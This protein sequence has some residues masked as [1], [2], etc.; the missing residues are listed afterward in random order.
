MVHCIFLQP[1]SKTNFRTRM[2]SP[3]DAVWSFIQISYFIL[4]SLL[5]VIALTTENFQDL[6]PLDNWQRQF[7]FCFTT[8]NF[9]FH[10]HRFWVRIVASSRDFYSSVSG[11]FT[12][13]AGNHWIVLTWYISCNAV[14]K[15]QFVLNYHI[16][17]TCSKSDNLIER[18]SITGIPVHT[19]FKPFY[20]SG[21]LTFSNAYTDN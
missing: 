20:R 11:R 21:I 16:P 15:T 9:L 12:L 17:A 1:L 6:L 5:T 13:S 3:F 7:L 4:P 10:Y 14:T 18:F 8:F 19:S 2:A